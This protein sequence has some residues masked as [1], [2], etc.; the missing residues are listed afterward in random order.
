M[1]QTLQVLFEISIISAPQIED[2]K[3]GI[4]NFN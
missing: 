2:G 1:L 4:K 3:Y